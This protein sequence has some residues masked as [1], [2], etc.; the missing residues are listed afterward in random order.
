MKDAIVIDPDDD[1]LD[2]WSDADGCA[3]MVQY[4]RMVREFIMIFVNLAQMFEDKVESAGSVI[5]IKAGD[6]K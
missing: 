1:M 5:R 6:A 2:R 3:A 4:W